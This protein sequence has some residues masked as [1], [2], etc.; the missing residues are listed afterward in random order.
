MTDRAEAATPQAP[1]R[2]DLY[3]G[4][5]SPADK[6]IIAYILVMTLL[7]CLSRERIPDWLAYV[8]RHALM[9]LAVVAVA[10]WFSVFAGRAGR[11][12]R[13]WYPVPLI[14]STYFELSYLIP[15]L[16]PRDFDWELARIDY[17]IFGAHPTVW[18]ERALWPP[19]TEVLQVAYAS[20]YFYPIILGAVLWGKGWSERFHFFVFIL[21]LGFYLSY[22]GYV[23]VPAIGPRFILAD[24]QTEP[25]AGLLL[26]PY[27]RQALDNASGVTRDCF[28]SG[29][30]ALTLLV[31][32]YAHR[33]HRRTFWSI[34]APASALIFSTVY[35][36]YHYVIDILA[37]VALAALVVV[38]AAP[39]YKLLN[40]NRAAGL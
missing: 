40:E 34:L 21:A 28:P 16:H 13:A 15:R 23:I 6:V 35:L 18:L 24:Q 2:A 33:F 8:V 14:P 25:L 10:K 39:L 4:S 7:V 31:L 1:K 32:Y 19:L 9:V 38:V 22:L 36:R 30:T 20:Y 11:F 3:A 26:F 17:R 5:L 37:G 27:I 29:H 12:V